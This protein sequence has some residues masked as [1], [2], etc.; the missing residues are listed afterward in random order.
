MYNDLKLDNLMISSQ[1]G[2]ENQ[3]Q[4]APNSASSSSSDLDLFSSTSVTLIDFGYASRY[5]KYREEKQG[6]Q[7]IEKKH[8]KVFRGNVY[9]SSPS[10]LKFNSTSRRDDMISLFYLIV[11]LF[12]QGKIPGI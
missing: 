7:H 4:H 6:W 11:Y 2:S 10:Q 3:N 5:L 1:I 12:K 8:K 9:F